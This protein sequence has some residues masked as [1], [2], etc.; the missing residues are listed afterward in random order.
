MDFLC[1][2]TDYH[3]DR[4]LYVENVPQCSMATVRATATYWGTATQ[5]RTHVWVPKI[6]LVAADSRDAGVQFCDKSYPLWG[7]AL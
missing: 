4:K 5:D 7:P 2:A 3:T 6:S 1:S